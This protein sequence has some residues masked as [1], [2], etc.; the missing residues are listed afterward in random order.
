MLFSLTV[1][2]VIASNFRFF[3]LSVVPYSRCAAMETAE[4]EGVA[5]NVS[6]NFS[7]SSLVNSLWRLWSMA[8]FTKVE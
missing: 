7:F 4:A 3:W 5:V 1:C 6:S 8:H 2:D